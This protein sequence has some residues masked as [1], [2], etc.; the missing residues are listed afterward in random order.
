[1][2]HPIDIIRQFTHLS[3]DLEERLRQLMVER[4]FR[5]GSIISGIGSLSAQAFYILQGSARL[6]YIHG[7]KERTFSFSF[8][9]EFVVVSNMFLHDYQ[10]TI[11]VQFLEN[12][13]VVAL[14]HSQVKTILEQSSAVSV[15]ESLVF[16]NV[17]LHQHAYALE[18]RLNIFQ[19]SSAEERYR[20]AVER[21][22]RLLETASGT[23]IA[24]FLGLTKETLYRIRSG[25]YR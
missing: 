10:D 19:H 6:F 7:G 24:S 1:M 11:S 25:N 3:P 13:K 8:D 22:P 12:T 16:L 21:Y 5:R 2:A 14:S 23:Q 20:W 9:D 18:E 15:P 17:A 4:R